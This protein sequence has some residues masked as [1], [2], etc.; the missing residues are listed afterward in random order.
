MHQAH[1]RRL[2]IDQLLR[3]ERRRLSR[4]APRDAHARMRTGARMIDVRT[5]EQIDRDGRV[6]TALEISLNVLEWRLDPDS[7][8]RHPAAPGLEQTV[9]VL[10]DEGYC[11]SLAAGRLQDLGFH[12]A[13]DV[14]GGFRAWR[15]LGLP[16]AADA[17]H[18]TRSR[19]N[20]PGAPSPHS[21]VVSR[22]A[23]EDVSARSFEDA[24][25]RRS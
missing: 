10:C 25:P 6:P 2:T 13:T 12:A 7:A 9:I 16:V 21:R 14:V 3:R 23:H 24:R 11:S 22:A 8:D 20:W 19:L 5:R 15:R 18:D 1:P 4:L 17:V